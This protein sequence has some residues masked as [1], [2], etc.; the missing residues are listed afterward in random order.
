MAAIFSGA[1]GSTKCAICDEKASSKAC[2]AIDCVWGVDCMLVRAHQPDDLPA[3]M[4]EP[5]V[6][7]ISHQTCDQKQVIDHQPS[8]TTFDCVNATSHQPL[9]N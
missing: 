9:H 7:G 5:P 3:H 1:E 6:V 8:T 2:V 4:Q